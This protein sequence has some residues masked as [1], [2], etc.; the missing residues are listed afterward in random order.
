MP[1]TSFFLILIAFALYGALHSALAADRTKAFAEARLGKNYRHYRLAY[2]LL[3]G[4][5]L[6]PVLFLVW[7]L[8]DAELWRIPWPWLLLS[9]AVQLAA[10][11]GLLLS[12]RV[13]GS[14][15]FLGMAQFL[16]LR[17]PARP[18]AL[19]VDGMYRYMR[20]PIY[21]F[22]LLILWL[23]PAMSSNLL[24]AALGITLY[25]LIGARLEERKLLRQFGEPYRAY[26]QAV[27]MFIPG[28][29]LKRE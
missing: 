29:K 22:S 13:T 18:E 14:L 16:H 7:R 1:L 19:R 17:Q 27:P 9:G 28:L 4:L 6:L 20:H 15:E 21:S 25:I 26:Q 24:A 11:L 12:F 5:A 23:T 8:P 10:G 2:N 3:S